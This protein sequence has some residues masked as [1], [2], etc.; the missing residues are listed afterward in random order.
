MGNVKETNGK[1]VIIGGGNAAIDAARIS[2]RLGAE[3]VRIVYR[4]TREEMPEDSIE[5]DEVL[6]EGV[7]LCTLLMP[8]RA[9][10]GN[11][12]LKGL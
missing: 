8:K 12:T 2:L 6:E 3:E 11:G 7:H 9:I 4:R 10:G 5:I 1:V